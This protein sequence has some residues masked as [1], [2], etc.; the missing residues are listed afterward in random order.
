MHF[1]LRRPCADCPW[2]NDKPHPFFGKDARGHARAA[3]IADSL[4]GM[5]VF[6]C[7]KTA[8]FH[9]QTGEQYQVDGTQACAGALAT[10][11][12]DDNLGALAQIA[13]RLGMF[14]TDI[15]DADQP[16][17]GSMDE[18]VESHRPESD[19]Q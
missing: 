1:K 3:E 7:H 2:R 9:E 4:Q 19:D 16:V 13:T 17:H 15:L 6:P 5:H 8:R 12:N 10:Q 14:D 18:W 11:L